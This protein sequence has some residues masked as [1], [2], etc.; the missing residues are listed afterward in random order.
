V[1]GLA[2]AVGAGLGFV[3]PVVGA[4]NE[5]N[6]QKGPELRRLQAFVG[7]WRTDEKF[8]PMD[9]AP[10]QKRGKGYMTGRWTLNGSFLNTE[11]HSTGNTGPYSGASMFTYD[12]QK[13]AYRLWWFDSN[14]GG[15]EFLGQ[16]DEAKRSFILEGKSTDRQDRPVV[17]RLTYRLADE[18]TIQFKLE[19][20]YQGKDFKTYIESTYTKIN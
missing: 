11:Y 12:S 13:K 17:K 14:G 8:Y 5:N 3:G 9:W 16:W 4:E 2:T 19:F 6:N 20:A 18:K 1:W 15:Q 7:G 10:R